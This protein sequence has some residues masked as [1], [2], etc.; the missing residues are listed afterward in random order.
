MRNSRVGPG[1]HISKAIAAEEAQIGDNVEIG[2]GEEAPNVLNPAIYAWG[3]ATIG[4]GTVIPE[5]M[6]IGKNTVVSGK[7]LPEDYPDG[8]LPGGGELLKEGGELP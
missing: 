5:G 6:K 7:T 2:I 3:L 4:E 1:A 8:F